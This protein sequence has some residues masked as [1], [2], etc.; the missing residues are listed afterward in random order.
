VGVLI[1]LYYL[2]M[3]FSIGLDELALA[4]AYLLMPVFAGL[5]VAGLL[6][7]CRCLGLGIRAS[8]VGPSK[9]TTAQFSIRQL[10]L[11]TLVV[12]CLSAVAKSLGPH[13]DIDRYFLYQL[14]IDVPF[15]IL[16]LAGVWAILGTRHPELGIVGVLLLAPLLGFGM[17]AV[18]RPV[19]VGLLITATTTAALVLVVSL[20]VIRRSGFRVARQPKGEPGSSGKENDVAHE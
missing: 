12:A 18:Y 6:A 20:Y 10:I 19:V 15:V 4:T 9:R 13:V 11:L 2:G 1:G 3:L 17:A 8:S 5:T 16:G 14:L 7:I